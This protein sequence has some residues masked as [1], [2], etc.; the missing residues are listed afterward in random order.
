[1]VLANVFLMN[2]ILGAIYEN[3]T[4]LREGFAAKQQEEGVKNLKKA[5]KLL[6]KDDNGEVSKNSIMALFCL[7][8]QNFPGMRYVP[9][10]EAEVLF[11]ILDNDNSDGIS[12]EE[13]LDFQQI[14]F[15]HFTKLDDEGKR[16]VD[17]LLPN[18]SKTE[19][20]KR[21]KDY[22]LS[23]TFNK[24]I[25]FL[26]VLNAV[27]IVY[28][29]LPLITG[30]HDTFVDKENLSDG[31]L[32]SL[33][34]YC[35][36]FFTIA[37]VLEMILKILVL[38]WIKYAVQHENMFD[39]VV[40]ITS[41]AATVMVYCFTFFNNGLIIRLVNSV[42]VLRLTRLLKSFPQFR[43]MSMTFFDIAK[44]ASKLLE[45]LVFI[46]YLFS[47]IGLVCFGGYVTRDPKNPNSYLLEGSDFAEQ[48]YWPN[49]FNDMMSGV[50][51][52]FNLMMYD[53]DVQ[54]SAF[55]L[56][57]GTAW[58]RL[59]FIAYFILVGIFVS[60]I[61]I[62]VIM[63]KF[64]EAYNEIKDV[65]ANSSKGH[66]HVSTGEIFESNVR[67]K[68]LVKLNKTDFSGRNCNLDNILEPLRG[69]EKL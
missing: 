61:V 2:V 32:D 26:L 44:P 5:Y 62:A 14:M 67:V 46:I 8:N 59:Y 55:E 16:L 42:R 29:N 35:Q 20:Y 66:H 17:Y 56:V 30:N 12:E 24:T 48:R 54:A 63:E 43:V 37:F 18:L 53:S 41:L 1:M 39:F 47:S 7:I 25:D 38:G 65:E 11:D 21:F 22:I 6:K 49:N 68:Y 19:Q 51:V 69:K 13:F 33:V 58:T 31:G 34:E 64:V 9:D 36:L 27:L 10:E 3:Y 52:L 15:L 45:F 57:A 60:N 4:N 23:E 50:V 40:T 28:Q